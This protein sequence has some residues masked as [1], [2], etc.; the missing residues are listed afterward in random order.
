[1]Q[2]AEPPVNTIVNLNAAHNGEANANQRY[3]RFAKKAE[4][5]GFAQVAKLF[6]AAA[7]S[8]AIHRELHKAAILTLG[9]KVDEVVLDEVNPGSTAENLAT[10]V[11]GEAYE[12]DSMY[13]AF[14]KQAK[15]DHAKAAVRSFTYALNAEAAH[16]KLY[17]GALANL[18]HNPTTD[19]FVNSICGFTVTALP[20]KECPSCH[21]PRDT[22]IQIN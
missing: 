9:G 21:N 2:A 12:R 20:A 4:A 10:A 14:L 7:A 13:P 19:Y 18:G 1:M 8:E 5:E 17:T 11:K 3:S 22:F 16:L 15:A 6:R